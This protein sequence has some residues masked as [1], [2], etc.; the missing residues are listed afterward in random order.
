MKL[1][2]FLAERGMSRADFAT[3]VGVSHVAITRYI[4][5][6][7]MPRM[8]HLCRIREV[9]GGAVTADDFMPSEV[10]AE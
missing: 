7:R 4:A 9:T 10:A 3:A 5:G 2:A 1:A 6:Q 8:E